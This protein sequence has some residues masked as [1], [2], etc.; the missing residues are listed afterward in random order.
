METPRLRPSRWYYA[1]AAAVFLAGCGSVAFF[2]LGHMERLRSSLVQVVAPGEKE[3]NLMQPGDYT[4]FYEQESVVDGRVYSTGEQ[5]SGLECQLVLLGRGSAIALTAPAMS[6]TYL[7]GGRSGRSI[8]RLRI[9]RS[10]AYLFSCRYAGGRAGPDVVLA[11][12]RDFSGR[13]FTLTVEA[14]AVV[15]GSLAIAVGIAAVTAVR[16][17]R[18]KK[19]LPLDVASPE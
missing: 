4:V 14:L 8:F 19:Q 2:L 17:E 12:G 13:V 16:R 11:I 7:I 18:A 9:E 15:L 6:T 1:V 3:L 10:G 5:L